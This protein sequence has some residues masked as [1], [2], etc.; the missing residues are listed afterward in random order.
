MPRNIFRKV[1]FVLEAIKP[2]LCYVF[3][4]QLAHPTV[5]KTRNVLI[6]VHN[7]WCRLKSVSVIRF[8]YVSV[9]LV[10]QNAKRMRRIIQGYS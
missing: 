2:K 10:I 3:I 1:F 9:V 4:P 7:H 8:E 5:N 6:N